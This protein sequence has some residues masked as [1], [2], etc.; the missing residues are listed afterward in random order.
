LLALIVLFG[1]PHSDVGLPRLLGQKIK[2]D[3]VI[4]LLEEDGFALVAALCN[5]MRKPRN[6][7]PGKT[8]HVQTIASRGE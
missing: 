7:D 1:G 5:V 2:V 3:F 4:A 8:C 6:H